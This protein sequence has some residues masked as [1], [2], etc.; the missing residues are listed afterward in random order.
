MKNSTVLFAIF[1]LMLAGCSGTTVVLVPDATGKVGKVSVKTKA[2]EQLLSQSGASTFAGTVDKA[3]SQVQVLDST[4]IQDMFGTA[5]ANEPAPPLHYS[6]YFKSGSAELLPDSKPLLMTM[7]KA[8]QERKSCDISV[9]GHSDRVGDNGTNKG[10]SL[11]RAESVANVLKTIGL[12]GD[13]LDV[14]YYGENDPVVPTAD[15]VAEPRNR[16]VE[17]EVR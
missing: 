12:S 4:K 11:K 3:P 14:R 5:L 15:N 13:C 7:F 8:I 2:G 6:I 1:G 17:I 10:I 16:R 9:I